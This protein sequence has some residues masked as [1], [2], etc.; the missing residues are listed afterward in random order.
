MQGKF[1]R[2]V[3]DFFVLSPWPYR[4]LRLGIGLL[5]IWRET[6]KLLHPKAFATANSQL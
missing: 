5:F 6:V 1:A 3:R 2:M 4:L